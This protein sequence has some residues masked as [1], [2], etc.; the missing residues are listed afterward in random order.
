MYIFNQTQ[1]K[2]YMK[3]FNHALAASV[4]ITIFITKSPK[5]ASLKNNRN[6]NTIRIPD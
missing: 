5:I 1:R 4:V 2:N 3:P 6:L